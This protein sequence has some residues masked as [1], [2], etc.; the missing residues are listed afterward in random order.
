MTILAGDIKLLASQRM[1]DN[2]DGGGRATGNVIVSGAHNTIFDDVSDVDLAYGRVNLRQVFPAIHTDDTDKYYGANVIVLTPPASDDVS[3]TLFDQGEPFCFRNSAREFIEQYLVKGPRWSGYLYD[4]QLKGQRAIRFFQRSEI[5]LPDVGETLVLVGDEGKPTQFEQYV[6]VTKV[7]SEVKTFE[8]QTSNGTFTR[9]VVTCEISDKLR[10]TFP[11][12]LPTKFDDVT[13]ESQLRETVVADAA[14]YYG[15]MAAAANGT[16]GSMQIQVKSI[17]SQLVPSARTDIPA[18]DLSSAGK[19]TALIASAG[20]KVT[21]STPLLIAPGKAIYLGNACMPGSVAISI[22]SATITDSAGELMVG[23]L[24]VGGVE[25][26]RGLLSFN[27]QCPNYGTQT[28]SVSFMPAAAPVKVSETAAIEVDANNRRY[29]YTYT[30]APIP[31]PGSVVLSYMVQGKWYD[32]RD[33]GNGELR[34]ADDSYGAGVIDLTTGSMMVTLGNLPDVGSM[35]MMT[36]AGKTVETSVS[37]QP[38]KPPLDP[39]DPTTPEPINKLSFSVRLGQNGLERVSDCVYSYG[40]GSSGGQTPPSIEYPRTIDPATVTASWATGSCEAHTDANGVL[41]GAATGRVDS[42]TGLLTL[43]PNVLP[44]AGDSLH[45]TWRVI[46][47]VTTAYPNCT[48]TGANVALS[49]GENPKPGSVYVAVKLKCSLTNTVDDKYND[50]T[51]QL[52]DNGSGSLLDISTR[53]LWGTVDYVS[54]AVVITVPATHKFW[55]QHYAVVAGDYRNTRSYWEELP[56]QFV[57]VPTV[58]RATSSLGEERSATLAMTSLTWVNVNKTGDGL[59]ADA[60]R[61]DA[62]GQTLTASGGQLQLTDPATGTAT[63]VGSVDAANQSVT[64]STWQAGAS[65]EVTAKALCAELGQHLVSQVAFRTPGAPVAP[66]SLYLW[67]IDKSGTR[68]DLTIAD[69]GVVRSGIFHGRFDYQM[70]IAKLTFGNRIL[71]AGHESEPWYSIDRVDADGYIIEPVLIKPD[72]IR[73][74][75]VMYSYIPLDADLIG[76]DPVRLPSDGRVPIFRTGGLVVVHSTE[77]TVVPNNP[78]AGTVVDVGRTRL[79]YLHV[80]DSAGVPLPVGAYQSDLDAGVVTFT[81]SLS[82]T[83]LIQP[84]WVVHRVEDMSLVRDVE[85]SGRLSL[86][87]QLSH[88]YPAASTLVSSVLLAGDRQARYTNLFDQ[89]TWTNE[90]SDTVIGDETSAQF[91]EVLY[92]ITVT[93]RG[94]ITEEWALIFTSASVFRIVGRSV[95]QIGVG[96]IT[97]PC[98]PN[99]PATGV[100]YWSINPLAFGSGWSAGNVLRFNTIGAEFPVQVAR[101]ILQSDASMADDKFA[102]Q[103]RGNVNK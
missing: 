25:Y 23:A 57:A 67:C 100:P 52:R 61:L 46:D 72:S 9:L 95:G 3:I 65:N 26:Q 42:A 20:S 48:V 83:G 99:N 91:N 18:T 93:N 59:V 28:K 10:Y 32:L 34:G 36:W 21:F 40:G 30:M 53:E 5:R 13:P 73:Y 60:T 89:A 96:D 33:S 44:V 81:A 86:A 37:P 78:I 69:S 77:K 54:G 62:A 2:D 22:G 1:T 14:T 12:N 98:A 84:L 87:R 90:W 8:T 51:V 85:I 74:N 7:S 66:G 92:P 43:C 29:A 102:L 75:C 24:V 19:S 80:E 58:T 16:F 97:T 6:R 41:I 39:V 35:V 63:T 27:D 64:V 31:S 55:V 71:A 76:L 45:L 49:L 11:G 38:V 68:H 17:Y 101:T 50:L 103:I 4:T 15:T 79:A 88:N 82:L 56:A 47:R 94:A 70:G